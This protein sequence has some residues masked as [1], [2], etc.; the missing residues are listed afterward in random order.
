MEDTKCRECNHSKA[1]CTCPTELPRQ[2]PII[3]FFEKYHQRLRGVK[4]R[5]FLPGFLVTAMLIAADDLE[6]QWRTP[7]EAARYLRMSI[8]DAIR[9]ADEG[10]D[11]EQGNPPCEC[12][13]QW[14]KHHKGVWRGMDVF[15]CEVCGC[16]EYNRKSA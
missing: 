2:A 12:D 1:D 5:D 9:L 8:D 16:P 6:N 11:E 7:K 3:T 4:N 10:E 15:S 13:H 14:S